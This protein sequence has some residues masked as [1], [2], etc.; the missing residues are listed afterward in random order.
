MVVLRQDSW[1]VPYRP[2]SNPAFS[3]TNTPC[4]ASLPPVLPAAEFERVDPSEIISTEL[5]LD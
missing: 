1:Q 3:P 2:I 4:F 5:E